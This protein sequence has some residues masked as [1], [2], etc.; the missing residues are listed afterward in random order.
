SEEEQLNFRLGTLFRA[1]GYAPNYPT[2]NEFFIPA[3]RQQ[4]TAVIEDMEAKEPGSARKLVERLNTM[5][6]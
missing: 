4:M 2:F 6:I 3:K 1:L 5:L